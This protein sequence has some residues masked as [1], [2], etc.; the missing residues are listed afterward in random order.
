MWTTPHI[1]I[2]DLFRGLLHLFITCVPGGVTGSQLRSYQTSGYSHPDNSVMMFP[3]QLVVES[4]PQQH[5]PAKEV[6]LC[7]IEPSGIQVHC[8]WWILQ[9]VLTTAVATMTLI[10][11]SKKNDCRMHDTQSNTLIL[12]ANTTTHLSITFTSEILFLENRCCILRRFIFTL[13]WKVLSLWC[14]GYLKVPV[15]IYS[16]R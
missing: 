1:N 10:S 13:Y 14:F 3:R 5:P 6:E 12:V 2:N 16:K 4:D 7:W 11:L 9:C 8:C 15:L